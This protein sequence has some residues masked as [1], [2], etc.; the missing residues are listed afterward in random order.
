[1]RSAMLK[2]AAEAICKQSLLRDVVMVNWSVKELAP[3]AAMSIRRCLGEARLKRHPN[4]G[5]F[6]MRKVADQKVQPWC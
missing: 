5:N 1:M 6:Q 3:E 4:M 2:G